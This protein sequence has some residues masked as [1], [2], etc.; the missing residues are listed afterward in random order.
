[1]AKD[2]VKQH[3]VPKRYLDRFATP[4]KKGKKCIG[5]RINDGKE[6]KFFKTTTDRIGY[7][8]NVYDVTDK[9]DQKHWEHYLANKFDYL[10]GNELSC[11]LAKI[12]LS[13]KC[14]NVL[15]EIDKDTLSKI[16][17]SQILRHPK[18]IEYAFKK[19]MSIKEKTKEQFLPLIP[20][21][22]KESVI[23]A[24][25]N[26]CSNKEEANSIFLNSVFNESRFNLY[27]G[28]LKQKTWIIYQNA[29]PDIV[30]FTTSDNPVLVID[31]A[32]EK[33]GAFNVGLNSVDTLV[34]F[35]LSPTAAVQLVDESDWQKR[36]LKAMVGAFSKLSADAIYSGHYLFNGKPDAFCSC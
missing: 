3:I 18:S 32:S 7:V 29:I 12:A 34:F 15:D 20:E 1:M 26:F 2:F 36:Y 11:I 35:P 30:P 10:Y 16:I 9:E 13:N 6:I 14:E 24:I 31:K 21:E 28:I 23:K 33:L 22:H 27:S 19:A 25:D 8:K 5:V 17:T 4:C